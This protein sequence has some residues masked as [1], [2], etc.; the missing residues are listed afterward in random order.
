MR[1][2]SR[3]PW[4]V[5]LLALGL[6][7]WLAVD[8]AR[9]TTTATG[10][11]DHTAAT[12]APD[13]I[14]VTCGE[15]EE[16]MPPVAAAPAL[17][18]PQSAHGPVRVRVVNPW[19]RPFPD[20]RVRVVAHEENALVAKVDTRTDAH[21][22]VDIADVPYDGSH[23][24]WVVGD[25]SA[26]I[27][28]LPIKRRNVKMVI[29]ALPLRVFAETS[30]GGR[31]LRGVSY[32]FEPKLK[33][34]GYTGSSRDPFV[35]L[36]PGDGKELSIQADPPEG[37]MTWDGCKEQVVVSPTARELTYTVPLR[38]EANVFVT[39]PEARRDWRFDVTVHGRAV[40]G[41]GATS[42]A[43]GRTR[44]RG[45][46]FLPGAGVHVVAKAE[47]KL[48][49]GTGAFGDDA[50]DILH[51]G[52]Q[53]PKPKKTK[54]KK[55][56]VVSGRVVAAN[57]ELVAG[58]LDLAVVYHGVRASADRI[59]AALFFNDDESSDTKAGWRYQTNVTVAPA[60]VLEALYANVEGL[61]LPTPPRA[62]MGQRVEIRVQTPRGAP[63]HGAW[64]TVAGVTRVA[65]AMGRVV[66]TDLPATEHR[67]KISGA[68]PSW[69]QPLEVADA[70]HQTHVVRVPRAGT[71]ELSVIGTNGDPLPHA[72]LTVAQAS[73][74]SW[75]DI[76]DGVQRLDRFTDAAGRRR[77]RNLQPDTDITIEAT[78]AGKTQR[79]TVRLA[80]GQ[81]MH[82]TLD[83]SRPPNPKSVQQAAN[84]D[85]FFVNF[86]G[87]GS[88]RAARDLV[89]VRVIQQLVKAKKNEAQ[90]K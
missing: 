15:E 50:G 57:G 25:P 22:R 68:G 5:V 29:Q 75:F 76:E 2:Q 35:M 58:Q 49:F 28:S 78:F 83:L 89:R 74:L 7:A 61:Q 34:G 90:D 72:R 11:V 13:L 55:G 27:Q 24:V 62:K 69:T 47:K 82:V 16:D 64:V 54:P 3:I 10:S 17:R 44:L 63:A 48:A 39:L 26:K 88:H 81:L 53:A 86:S 19:G 79:E 73:G 85:T 60:A 67:V 45:V 52:L 70:R 32:T 12:R 20:W 40:E 21:G 23:V 84:A 56:T 33:A 30:D 42:D 9:P 43:F 65:D 46:P 4:L 37:Y 66:F 38:P 51:M 8:I 6:A 1:R 14:G 59:N 41:V 77:L 18:V 80:P 71:I 36:G 31:S 87:G